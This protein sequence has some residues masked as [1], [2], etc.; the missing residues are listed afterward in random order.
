MS[1]LLLLCLIFVFTDSTAAEVYRWVDENGQVH[2]GQRPPPGVSSNEIRL[3]PAPAA[4][5]EPVP[6]ITPLPDVTPAAAKDNTP[7][8]E[9]QRALA[10]TQAKQQLQYVESRKVE[11]PEDNPLR[12]RS[13]QL[14]RDYESR[15]A[16]YENYQAAREAQLQL[17][18]QNCDDAPVE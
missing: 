3:A 9:Q 15:L 13:R 5:I 16:A 17:I 10:C 18:R 6:E 4:E 7:S 12:A 8:P 14:Q 1:F 2:Y 11:K